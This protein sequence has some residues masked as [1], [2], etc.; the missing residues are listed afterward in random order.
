MLAI[1]S[2][3]NFSV[4]SQE[5]HMEMSFAVIFPYSCP[6]TGNSHAVTLQEKALLSYCMWEPYVRQLCRGGSTLHAGELLL[7]PMNFCIWKL[8]CSLLWLITKVSILLLPCHKNVCNT[9]ENVCNININS[10]TKFSDFQ[11]ELKSCP[12]AG[13]TF[14]TRKT[15]G[16]TTAQQSRHLRLHLS[17]FQQVYIGCN[18]HRWDY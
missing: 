17:I 7:W 16:R 3:C 2:N 15:G 10:S 18:D 9:M 1:T 8:H 12:N 14:D 13:E 4:T 6:F 11:I 5:F